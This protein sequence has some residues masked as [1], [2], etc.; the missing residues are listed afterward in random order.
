MRQDDAGGHGP[1]AGEL[2]E[3]RGHHS[4][5]FDDGALRRLQQRVETPDIAHQVVGLSLA[6]LFHRRAGTK[7]AEHRGGTV[8]RQPTTGPTRDDAGQKRME[9]T[10]RLGVERRQVLV[11]FHRSRST[12]TWSSATTGRSRAERRAAMAMDNASLGSFFWDL[13]V[14]STRARADSVGGTSKTSSPAPTSCF[15]S[16]APS[17]LADSM[18]HDR[19]GNADAQLLKASSCRRSERTRTSSS[20]CSSSSIATAVCDPLWGSSQ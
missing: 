3:R 13:P 11:G 16:S 7:A 18:A 1:H 8:G 17:P 9:S 19:S 15:Y 6:R 5:R 2:S 12:A 20:L 4:Q 10:H 14:P